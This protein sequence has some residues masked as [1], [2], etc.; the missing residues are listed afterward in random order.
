MTIN[1]SV[2]LRRVALADAPAILDGFRAP[3]MS[4]QGEVQDEP[5]A[6]AYTRALV[7]NTYGFAL[8][9]AGR[10]V[11]VVAVDADLRNRLGWFWYWTKPSHRGRGL[12][13]RA[14]ATV[15]NW[16]LG[17]GGLERLELG[18]RANNPASGAVARA[19]GFIQEGLER[20]KFLVE[21]RRI[22]VLTYGRLYSDP[23]PPT[24]ELP[25]T[26]G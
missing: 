20:E 15:A 10:L 18:H 12:T 9:D 24:E 6:A 2:L 17:A 22:D 23:Q 21:G 11:G 7:E 1:G 26:H 19:A 16:A 4:R 3:D 13:A 5:S 8:A 14:A 25:L